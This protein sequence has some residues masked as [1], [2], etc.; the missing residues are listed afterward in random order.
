MDINLLGRAV[1][2]EIESREGGIKD[3]LMQDI[4]ELR[5]LLLKKFLF[6]SPL[7]RMEKG[8]WFLEGLFLVLEMVN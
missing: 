3:I 5:R 6:Y 8:F 1:L 7:R 4:C 2:R